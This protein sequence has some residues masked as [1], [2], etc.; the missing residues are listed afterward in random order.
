M[1]RGLE[2]R[3]RTIKAVIFDLDDT[4]VESTVNFPKFKRLVV[5]RIASY[6]EDEKDYGIG[7]TIVAIINRFEERMVGKGVPQKEISRRLAEMDKIMDTVEMERVSETVAYDGAVRLLGLLRKHD[8][9][10]GILTR[11]CKEYASSA[12]AKTKLADLVDEVE[13]RNSETKAK[14]N[15][16]AY[17]KLAAALGVRKDE[18]IF[19]GDHPMDGQCAANAGVPFVSVLTG[20]VSEEALR[21]AGSVEVFEDIGRLADWLEGKLEA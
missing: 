4:L 12:L 3:I 14:P 8:I 1:N 9:K 2:E 21:R 19:V 20:D 16:E 15:P 5:E 18:T 11:G 7:E 17:L 13:C 10:V 6:G